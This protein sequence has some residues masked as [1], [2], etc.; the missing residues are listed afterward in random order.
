M[1]AC[2]L[3]AK[4]IVILNKLSRLKLV[5]RML[6]SAIKWL[7]VKSNSTINRNFN[8]SA[9]RFDDGR[10]LTGDTHKVNNFEKRLLV[11]VGKYKRV[12]DIPAYV[13]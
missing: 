8:S 1:F 5:N 7:T 11:W 10:R 2:L 4:R 9:I 3:I 13:A 6:S 12:E